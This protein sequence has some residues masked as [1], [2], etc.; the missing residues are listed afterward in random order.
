MG[1]WVGGWVGR[2]VVVGANS[3]PLSGSDPSSFCDFGVEV[4]D[5]FS[6]SS[7]SSSSSSFYGEEAVVFCYLT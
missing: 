1:G 2:T 6:S 5:S 4:N 7:S 3:P